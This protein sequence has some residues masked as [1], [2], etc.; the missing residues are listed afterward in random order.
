MIT[1]TDNV[2]GVMRHLQKFA[3]GL[4]ATIVHSVRDDDWGEI[5]I[6]RAAIVLDEIAEDWERIFIPTFLSGVQFHLLDRGFEISLREQP[7]RIPRVEEAMAVHEELHTSRSSKGVHQRREPLMPLPL[8]QLT[9][10]EINAYIEDWVAEEKDKTERD[11]NQSDPEIASRLQSILFCPY[12]SEKLDAARE[13][14]AWEINKYIGARM[15]DQAPSLPRTGEW[16]HAIL[17][18]RTHGWRAVILRELPSK[19]RQEIRNLWTRAGA[20]L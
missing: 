16:L 6:R 13:G 7:P 10:D 18:H 5:L 4:D 19:T 3:D 9:L 12:K 8:Q 14:L 1:I 11:A 17:Y 20:E 2:S 15:A